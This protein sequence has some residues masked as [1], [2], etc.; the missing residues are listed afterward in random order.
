MVV[1][2][3]GRVSGRRGDTLKTDGGRCRRRCGTE[4][5]QQQT[6]STHRTAVML[7]NALFGCAFPDDHI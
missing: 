3:G 5:K 1:F 6:K 2:A 4:E 7:A